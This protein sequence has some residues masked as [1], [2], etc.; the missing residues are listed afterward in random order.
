M[1]TA[2]RLVNPKYYGNTEAGMV[3]ALAEIR[4]LGCDFLVAGRLIG[5]DFVDDLSKLDAPP[6]LM[7][8]FRM[9]PEFRRDISSTELR[10]K[11]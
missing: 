7:D 6:C 8:M 3:S 11:R 5:H 10:S 1:D 4:A 2:I 9:M